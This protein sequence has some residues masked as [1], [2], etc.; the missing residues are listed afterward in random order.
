[1]IEAKIMKFLAENL[2]ED[3]YAERP[4]DLPAA[5]YIVEKVGSTR[6]NRL[7]RSTLAIKSCAQKFEQ[8]ANMNEQ[9]K[10]VMLDEA[11]SLS[12]VSG[13]KLNSD[14]NNTDPGEGFYQY[15]AVF[16]IYH[17]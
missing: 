15:Q 11:V 1:M 13:I 6:E 9:L 7:Y 12:A 5:F 4:A 16:D 2:S 3:T 10:N 14:Y 8:A 17:F